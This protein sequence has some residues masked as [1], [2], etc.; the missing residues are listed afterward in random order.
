MTGHPRRFT[1]DQQ[2][3]LNIASRGLEK[4]FKGS[5][6]RHHGLS[7]PLLATSSSES[8][9]GSKFR[10]GGAGRRDDPRARFVSCQLCCSPL[11]GE[12][13]DKFLDTLFDLVA[14]RADRVHALPGRVG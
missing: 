7:L 6:R 13:R 10:L 12:L 11:S 8:E 3:T 5:P 4:E 1:V 14:D 9:R 2:Y